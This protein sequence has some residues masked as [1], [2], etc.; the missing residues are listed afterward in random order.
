AVGKLAVDQAEDTTVLRVR[1][2]E[3]ARREVFGDATADRSGGDDEHDGTD[4]DG[5]PPRDN[6]AGQTVE[7]VEESPSADRLT[8]IG[9][10]QPAV[11]RLQDIGH[12]RSTEVSRGSRW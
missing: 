4:E 9:L 1:V 3:P 11:Q 5:A 12:M 10:E 8:A 7:H 6:P 2:V